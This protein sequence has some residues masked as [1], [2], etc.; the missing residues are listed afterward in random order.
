[1]DV[2]IGN[3]PDDMLNNEKCP[4]GPYMVVG[5]TAN[6]YAEQYHDLGFF[7]NFGAE[8]WCNREGQYVFIVANVEHLA[9]Q[10]YE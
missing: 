6:S 4:G 5:D 8:I 2:Y 9:G 1:M 3:D 10:V 7:W